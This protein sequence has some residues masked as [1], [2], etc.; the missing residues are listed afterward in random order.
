MLTGGVYARVALGL[1]LIYGVL[2]IVSF[3][4]GSLLMIGMSTAYLL[5]TKAGVNPYLGPRLVAALMGGLGGLLHRVVG[6]RSLAARIGRSCW[7][8]LDWRWC[9]TIWPWCCSPAIRASLRPT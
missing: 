1:T 5:A 7:R 8:H 9:S 3:A 4:H 6:G 2:H